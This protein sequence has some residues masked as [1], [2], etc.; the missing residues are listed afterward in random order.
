MHNQSNIMLCIENRLQEPVRSTH[1]SSIGGLVLFREAFSK[2]L[3]RY[4]RGS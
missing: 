1:P 4:G 3:E 2:P